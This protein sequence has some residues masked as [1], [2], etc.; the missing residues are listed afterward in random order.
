MNA[1][2]YVAQA[3]QVFGGIRVRWSVLKCRVGAGRLGFFSLLLCFCGGFLFMVILV[4]L[5]LNTLH[6]LIKHGKTEYQTFFSDSKSFQIFFLPF[7]FL[8]FS[9]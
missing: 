9:L 5:G 6:S 7:S 8:F 2:G 3:R 4:S 1:G